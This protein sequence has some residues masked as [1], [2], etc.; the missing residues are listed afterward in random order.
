[1]TCRI[2]ELQYKELVDITDGTRYG[3]IGDLEVD[4]ESGAIQNI[5]IYGRSRAFGLLGREND[6][7]FPWSAIKR[8]GADLILIDGSIAKSKR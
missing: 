1:M 3:C 4:T 5:I 2:A 7:I 8:I 6:L